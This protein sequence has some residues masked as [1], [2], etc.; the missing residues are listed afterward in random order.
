LEKYDDL[1]D[2]KVS[3]RYDQVASIL[4]P[5]V[6]ISINKPIYSQQKEGG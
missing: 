1:D 2:G 5:D 3:P 4:N 6:C